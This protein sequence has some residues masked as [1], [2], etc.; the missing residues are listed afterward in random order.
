MTV[1]DINVIYL[2]KVHLNHST[3]ELQFLS[4]PPPTQE[5]TI[6]SQANGIHCFVETA[7]RLG[8][9]IPKANK[10]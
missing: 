5:T 8:K 6:I 9:L 7:V 2:S 3:F 4:P 10:P 1:R